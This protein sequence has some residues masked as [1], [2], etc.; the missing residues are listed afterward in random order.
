MSSTASP[1]ATVV[2]NLSTSSVQVI[3]SSVFRRGISFFNSNPSGN[4][5]WV[6][7]ANLTAVANQ[8]ILLIAGANYQIPAS[9]AANAAFNAIASTGSSNVLTIIEFF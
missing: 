7:P 2:S 5:M 3:G 6:V 9:L 4:N 8:G 1:K